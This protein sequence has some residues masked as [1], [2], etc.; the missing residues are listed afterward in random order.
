MSS[1]EDVLRIMSIGA[2]NRHVGETKMNHRSSRS[3]QVLT[4]MV[5]GQNCVTGVHTH[6]CL[7][8]I[9]LAGSERVQRSEATGDRLKEAQHI[10]KSLSALGDVMSSLANGNSHVPYRNSKLTQ[11]LQ[12]SLGGQAKTMMFMHISPEI[13]SY[14]ETISTLG[15][16]TRVSQ[17][18]PI[19]HFVPLDGIAALYNVAPLLICQALSAALGGRSLSARPSKTGRVQSCL[20]PGRPLHD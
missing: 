11:L 13:S 14:G 15:F 5:D 8:L 10:N 7:N 3:H 1:T 20:Q 2:K 9:D 12:D 4:V 17:V 16:G 18:F 6:A 19:P